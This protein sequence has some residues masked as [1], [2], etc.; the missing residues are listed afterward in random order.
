MKNT[1]L[2]IGGGPA[3]I[4]AA[5][6]LC[7]KGY[8]VTLLEQ[9]DRLGG[10]LHGVPSVLFGWHKASLALLDSLGT[11]DLVTRSDSINIEFAGVHRARL[12][13]PLL[14][15]PLHGVLGLALFGGLSTRD[16]VRALTQI[17]RAWEGVPPLP[18][19]LDSRTADRWLAEGGQSETA[20][21]R[22]WAPLARFF[23]GGDLSEVSASMLLRMFRDCFLSSRR[24]SA[25][26]IPS[27]PVDALL[28]NPALTQ[29]KRADASVRLGNP[30]SQII[31]DAEK[32]TG[33]GVESGETLT[34]D[35]YVAAI[36]HHKL[37]AV[38]SD[39]TLTRFSYFEQLTR[40][41][42]SPAVTIHFKSAQA[43]WPPR[44]VLLSG[45]TFH[46]LVTHGAVKTEPSLPPM[47]LVSVGNKDL[48]AYDDQHLL[49][50]ARSDLNRA[51]PDC[52]HITDGEALIVRDSHA[53]LSLCPGSSTLRPL[54]QGPMANLLLAGE[55]TDT[56]L[57]SCLESAVRSGER[58]AATIVAHNPSPR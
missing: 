9:S 24:N 7:A 2:V 45:L 14:P 10:R 19:D 11:A 4:A 42:D 12:G 54:E 50:L 51:V 43:P 34:A 21:N 35:W 56:G 47:S 55:W 6:R 40:L 13:R 29:L 27:A 17:E 1:V 57:P 20:R 36:P 8:G 58:C 31:C 49:Q 26:A 18:I 22:I 16:R 28:V 41:T 44:L 32:V 37:R 3:G 5:V 15:G 48:L 52:S 30:V 46:W 38:L 39:R 53:C 33:V 25:L 23:L